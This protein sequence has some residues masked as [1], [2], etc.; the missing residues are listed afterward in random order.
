MKKIWGVVGVAIF[1]IS[2]PITW[3]AVNNS[4]RTRVLIIAKDEVLLVKNWLGRNRWTLPGGGAHGKETLQT[5]AAREIKEELGLDVDENDLQLLF[6]KEGMRDTGFRFDCD[7]F[8]LLLKHKPTLALDNLE[9]HEARWFPLGSK[10]HQRRLS[11]S[12]HLAL[13]ALAKEHSLLN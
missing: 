11:P 3:L 2:W 10:L 5:A 8:L 4:R 13:G 1:W 12:A 7:G 9:M 6:Q